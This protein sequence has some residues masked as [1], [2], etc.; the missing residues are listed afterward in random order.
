LVRRSLGAG[1]ERQQRRKHHR[2]TPCAA[3]EAPG[4]G[5][6]WNYELKGIELHEKAM[7][8]FYRKTGCG[9]CTSAPQSD[10]ELLSCVVVEVRL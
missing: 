5:I 8:R 3:V 9:A 1:S 2:C 10:S 6:Y 7:N 4:S